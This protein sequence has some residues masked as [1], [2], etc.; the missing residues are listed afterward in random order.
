[1]SFL[2]ILGLTV[3]SLGLVMLQHLVSGHWG[4]IIRRPAGIGHSQRFR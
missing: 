2:L 1:M 3:G 4:I